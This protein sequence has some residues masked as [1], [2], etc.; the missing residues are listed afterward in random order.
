M[1]LSL[2]I[3]GLC[4]API[5]VIAFG[6]NRKWDALFDGYV[7]VAMV[8]LVGWEMLPHSIGEGGLAA[9]V[10]IALGMLFPNWLERKTQH[11]HGS[12]AWLAFAGLLFHALLD[13][14]ALGYVGG[15][16]HHGHM[17]GHS[18]G[19]SLEWAVILHRL[20]VGLMVFGMVEQVRGRLAALLAIVA[21]S[22][23]TVAGFYGGGAI[24]QLMSSDVAVLFEAFIIGA[25]LHVVFHDHASHSHAEDGA[26]DACCSSTS[27]GDPSDVEEADAKASDQHDHGDHGHDDHDHAHGAGHDHRDHAHDDH[28]H[29]H[30]DHNHGHDHSHDGHSHGGPAAGVEGIGAI[31]GF[32]TLAFFAFSG[33]ASES[34]EVLI[35]L[36]LESAPAL[37][38]AYLAAG[39]LSATALESGIAWMARGSRSTQA[40]RGMAFGLPLPVCSCGV[41]PL[42]ESL[43]KKGAPATAAFAFLVATPELGVDAVLLSIPLLGTEL[44]FARV[45]AAVVVAVIAAL[46]VGRMVTDKP[47]PKEAT[48]QRP[49]L[50]ERVKDGLRYGLGELVDHTLPWIILGIAVAAIVEPLIS[51]TA[52]GNMSSWAQVPLFAVLGIPLYICAS[53]ATPF[54]AVLIFSGVSPGAALAFLLTGPATNVTTFGVLQKLHSRKVAV[55]F[56]VVVTLTAVL[57]GWGVDI[58][59]PHVEVALSP[60]DHS[61]APLYQILSVAAL[62]ALFLG[63]LFRQGPRGML[64]QVFKPHQ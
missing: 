1:A 13:G 50:R 30:G 10:M 43:A 53:G 48:T 3:L 64:H 29:A 32:A 18:H 57:C 2:S 59:L 55:V 14:G 27:C 47:I 28:H 52:F 15:H 60:H 31:F 8:G 19:E 6:R 40:V 21:L 33:E 25:L 58:A 42:Y 34:Q 26:D 46:I 12:V 22:L 61:G 56:G 51:P 44:A 7:L 54:A 41:L 39:L 35:H 20:P 17:H 36:V 62:A 23:A 16:D 49:P 9:A 24:T 38:F 11:G 5:L 4:I 37:V 45:A 63:S